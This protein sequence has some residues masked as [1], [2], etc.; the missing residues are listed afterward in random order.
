[1]KEILKYCPRVAYEKIS[2]KQKKNTKK[3]I[4]K[5]KRARLNCKFKKYEVCKYFNGL[6]KYI[7][8]NNIIFFNKNIVFICCL[9]KESILWDN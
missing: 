6:K 2:K 7:E 3:K 8:E 9:Y 5:F 4:L 1:M